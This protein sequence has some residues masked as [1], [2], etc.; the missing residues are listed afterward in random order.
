VIGEY[1][2]TRKQM[3]LLMNAIEFPLLRTA[4]GMVKPSSVS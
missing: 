2:E 4:I 3:G 1:R